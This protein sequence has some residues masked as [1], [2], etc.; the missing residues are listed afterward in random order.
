[1]EVLHSTAHID[2]PDFFMLPDLGRTNNPRSG[3]FSSVETPDVKIAAI[4]K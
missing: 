3:V 2:V 4:P 1:M